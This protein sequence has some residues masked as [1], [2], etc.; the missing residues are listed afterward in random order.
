MMGIVKNYGIPILCLD[1]W[2]HAYFLQYKN[3]RDEYVKAFW[4]LINWEKVAKNLEEA[5]VPRF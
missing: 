3:R 2:E 1:L 5:S 4:N